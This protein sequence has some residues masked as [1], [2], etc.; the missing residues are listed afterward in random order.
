MGSLPNAR[1]GS[2]DVAVPVKS[3]EISNSEA[4]NKIGRQSMRYD[5]VSSYDKRNGKDPCR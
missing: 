3:R 2:Y 5:T 4:C 1:G